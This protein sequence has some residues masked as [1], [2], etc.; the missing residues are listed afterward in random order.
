MGII[1]QPTDKLTLEFTGDHPSV[2]AIEITRA[3]GI[4]TIFILGDSTVCDQ[5]LEPYASWGQ[6]LPRFFKSGIAI[7]KLVATGVTIAVALVQISTM[8]STGAMGGSLEIESKAGLGTVLK[9][10]LPATQEAA[11]IVDPDPPVAARGSGA[12]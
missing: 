11:A 7:A 6:M 3:D 2:S 9:F 1:L 8:Q 4:S 12:R 5:P 10:I